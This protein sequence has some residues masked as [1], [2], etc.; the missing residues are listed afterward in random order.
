MG[1]RLSPLAL[2]LTAL[3]VDAVGIHSL[4][5]VLVL[6]AVAAAA[7]AA[8]VGVGDLVAGAGSWLCAVTSTAA[9]VLLLAGSVARAAAPVGAHV[10]TLAISTLV[11]AAIVYMLPLLTWVVAPVLPK[12]RLPLRTDP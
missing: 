11:L 6:A 12:P 7:A 8:F 2:S 9:L 1:S 4:A 3:G 10:P 5:S